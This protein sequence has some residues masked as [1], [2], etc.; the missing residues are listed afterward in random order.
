MEVRFGL[1]NGLNK[2]QI[3]LLSAVRASQINT[4]GWPI[5][6]LLENRPEFR[7]IAT[8]Y[9]VSSYCHANGPM[10][11]GDPVEGPKVFDV[12]RSKGSLYLE[13]ASDE[14]AK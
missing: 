12:W 7:L 4:F 13:D 3:E 8:K 9:R 2:S 11:V 1:H 5:A 10:F 6:V 14:A